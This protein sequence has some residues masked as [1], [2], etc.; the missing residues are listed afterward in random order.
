MQSSRVRR[1][2][3]CSCATRDATRGRGIF[4]ADLDGLTVRRHLRVNAVPVL[5]DLI[6]D[7]LRVAPD[8]EA[9][10]PEFDSDPEIID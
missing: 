1:L 8:L 6:H 3:C 7:Q 5:H 4:P 9:F 2:L 10:D